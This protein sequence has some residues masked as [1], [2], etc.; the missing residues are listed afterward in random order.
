MY[1]HYH[2]LFVGSLLRQGHLLQL[3][4]PASSGEAD[5]RLARAE[6]RPPKPKSP[7]SGPVRLF[8]LRADSFS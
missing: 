1:P 4:V 6:R 7:A 5:R 8:F 3:R 2:C